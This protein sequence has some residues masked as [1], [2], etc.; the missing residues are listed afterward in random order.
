M[1]TVL[2]AVDRKDLRGSRLNKIRQSGGIPAV[3]YGKSL[4]TTPVTVDEIE[5]LK[6]Y[7]EVGKTG[8]FKLDKDGKKYDVMIY[9]MQVDR[10]KNEFV[11]LDFYAVDMKSELDAD[12]PVNLIGESKGAKEGGV[13]QLAAYE[14]SVKALPANLP[15]SIDLDVSDLDVNDS[16]Q[17]KDIKGVG[18]FE[19]NND[20]EEVVVSVLP[21]TEEPEEPATEGGE[22]PEL[23]AAEDG[24]ENS[25]GEKEE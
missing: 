14:L 18:D 6:T 16:I 5:F 3:L 12:I 10:I 23:V 1:V 9:D 24:E 2:Q 22:E 20:P 19:F 21:P 7:R 25:Q 8:V 17:V 11:H 13:V 4:D 15:D